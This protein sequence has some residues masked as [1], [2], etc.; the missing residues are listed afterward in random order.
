MKLLQL[1]TNLHP[2]AAGE[3]PF[4][5]YTV[6]TECQ[7]AI[8]RIAGFSARQ[9]FLT[10][11]GAGIF[12]PLGQKNWDTLYPGTLLYLPPDFPHEYL[13]QSGAEWFVGY[14]TYVERPGG[15]LEGLGFRNVPFRLALGDPAPLFEWIERIWSHSGPN[16]DVWR[17]SAGLF[18]LCLEL[19]KRAGGKNT[20]EPAAPVRTPRYRDE[21][22]ENAVRFLHDHFQRRLTMTELASHVGYSP[23]HLNRLFRESLGETPLQYLQRLRI[24]TAALL[25]E[26]T[27]HM[28]VRQAA[29][30]VGMEPVY[31]TRLFRRFYGR[32]PSA[33]FPGKNPCSGTAITSCE[34][35]WNPGEP[36]ESC[37]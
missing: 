34:F 32:A 19:K 1:R 3:V 30:H 33:M 23:K 14:V 24:R 15:P 37:P 21:V 8:T 28:T 7:K 27:P 29:A 31:F 20:P 16:F 13:P 25:L 5:V 2:P 35:P 11:S 4:T 18:S 6:G 12:R 36:G 22:V 26:R 9:L 10:F 17:S